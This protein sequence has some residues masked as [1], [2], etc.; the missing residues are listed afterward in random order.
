MPV[1][2]SKELP[3]VETLQKE[4]IFALVKERASTQDIRPLKI[5][6]VNL[7]PQKEATELQ[8]LRLLSQSPIQL[9]I[10]LLKMRTHR[11]KTASNHHL[12]KFYQDFLKLQHENFDALIVTGAPVETMPFE[13]VDYWAELCEI[14]KWSQKHCFSCLHI[15]WG[16][17][18]GLFFHYGI[19]KYL[20]SQKLFGIYTQRV[21]TPHPLL[22]G[23]NDT[24]D[25][26]QS[27]YTG[28][29][30]EAGECPELQHL[31]ENAEIGSTIFVSKDQKN[32]FVLGHLEYETETLKEE[33]LRDLKKNLP[34]SMPLNYFEQNNP[35]GRI[36]N[37]WRCSASLFFHNWIN[38]IYQ[39]TPYDLAELGQY[40]EEN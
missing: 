1:I 28:I 37:T 24:F 38:E 12:D 6:I 8:L 17:Q 5:V 25:C 19:E 33:F 32:I 27:R 35:H 29:R 2:I 40:V 31:D 7:M 9:D 26:P 20:Y 15:C 4:N 30:L 13:K 39:Q 18:A 3:A 10:R 16:A 14:L 11:A 22:R 36:E 34:T 23:F 21:L